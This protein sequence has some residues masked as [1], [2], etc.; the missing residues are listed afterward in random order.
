M[1][2]GKSKSKNSVSLYVLKSTYE[3]GFHSTKIVEKLGTTE[4]LAKKLNGEDPIEWAK[5]YIEELNRKEKEEK[6]E[7]KATYS[8]SRR[9]SRHE[10]RT[11]NGGYLFLEPVVNELGIHTICRN[12]KKRHHLDFNFDD[13]LC[14]LIY[15][16][17]VSPSSTLSYHDCASM[18]LE[19]PDFTPKHV[20]K[21]LKVLSEEASYIE[22]QL[23]Q[24]TKKTHGH[25]LSRLYYDT[26]ICLYD[27]YARDCAD[28]VIPMEIYY[29]ADMIPLGYKINP[30]HLSS[31]P[32]SQIE[33]DLIRSFEIRDVVSMSDGGISAGGTA[34]FKDW[35]IPNSYVT[36]MPSSLLNTLQK[37][38]ANNPAGWYCSDL[39]GQFNLRALRLEQELQHP[40]RFYWKDIIQANGHRVILCYSLSDAIRN[41]TAK[42][43]Y[44]LHNPNALPAITNQE[45]AYAKDVTAFV[46]NIADESAVSIV[47][48]GLFREQVHRNFRMLAMEFPVISS[49]LSESEMISAHFITCY[50]ALCVWCAFMKDTGTFEMAPHMQEELSDMNFMKVAQEGYVPLYTPNA[51]TDLLHD[52]IGYRTDFEIISSKQIGKIMRNSKRKT[53][54]AKDSAEENPEENA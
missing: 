13:I 33:E 4:E 36:A 27:S 40:S 28:H 47:R 14:K 54:I 43:L 19:Q 50:C 29:D 24:N 18:F 32:N 51:F 22:Q 17:L 38:E 20:E 34:R 3:Y 46:T 8:P 52:S 30:D 16:R 31:Q 10:N 45:K 35:N 15:I 41:R 1:H 44:L 42:E 5:K 6:K 37:K 9:I 48:K 7:I 26:T 2:L 39:P 53:Y 49:S 11:F 25:N 12:I 23:Y 21:A